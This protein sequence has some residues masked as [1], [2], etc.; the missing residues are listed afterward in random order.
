[1]TT[2][3]TGGMGNF[4]SSFTEFGTGS[5]YVAVVFMILAALPFV[6]FIQL[7]AGS[8]RPLLRDTQ[9]QGCVLVIVVFVGALSLGL[10]LP[11]ESPL[12]PGFRS[13]LFNVVSIGTGTGYSSAAYDLWGPL[14]VTMFFV[15]GLIGGCS[16]STT[17]SVKVFRYQLLLS[18]M[19]AEVQRLHSPNRVFVPRYEGRAVSQDVM[20]SVMAF[21]M[22]FFLSLAVTAVLLVLL[23]LEPVTAISGAASAMANIGPGLGPE[24]GPSGNFAGLPDAAKWVLLTAM[25]VGRLEVMSVFVL[26]TAAFWRA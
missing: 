17:C 4:D 20:N 6:R 18:A 21:F 8:A 1:M 22:M 14:A 3:S 16:G 15:L 9:I 24:I 11:G 10:S 25:L 13:I 23:G 19:T 26:F 2:V 7:A 5:Q 12:E